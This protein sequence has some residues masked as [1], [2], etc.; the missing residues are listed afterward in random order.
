MIRILAVLAALFLV[1]PAIAQP[2]PANPGYDEIAAML[3]LFKHSFPEDMESGLE[4]SKVFDHPYTTMPSADRK[5]LGVFYPFISVILA[6]SSACGRS[7]VHPG[8]SGSSEGQR[9][10]RHGRR[11]QVRNEVRRRPESPQPVSP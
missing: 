8:G 6:V 3:H 1:A 7:A 4:D 2:L 11:R 9:V 10:C 5:D